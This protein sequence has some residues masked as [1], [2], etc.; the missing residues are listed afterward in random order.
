MS[1]IVSH[2]T[3]A[4]FSGFGGMSATSSKKNCKKIIAPDDY[5]LRRVIEITEALYARYG[6]NS[7]MTYAVAV[8]DDSLGCSHK[9]ISSSEGRQKVRPDVRMLAPVRSDEIVVP[10]P[11]TVE[12]DQGHAEYNIVS[13][14]MSEGW[15]LRSIGATRPICGS[16]LRAIH[17]QN[18]K[19]ITLIK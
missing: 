16:C 3:P 7:R 8:A 18:V 14:V 11:G 5:V 15:K 12:Y 17:S 6:V 2:S 13:I 9:L 4:K 1:G 19:P 10:G